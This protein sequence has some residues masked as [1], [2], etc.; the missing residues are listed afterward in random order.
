MFLSAK[1]YIPIGTKNNFLTYQLTFLSLCPACA[2]ISFEI[3]NLVASLPLIVVGNSNIKKRYGRNLK[4]SSCTFHVLKFV[5]LEAAL[6]GFVH[7]STSLALFVRLGFFLESV[8]SSVATWAQHLFSYSANIWRIIVSFFPH[9]MFTG[10]FEDSCCIAVLQCPFSLDL[11][12][13][14]TFPHRLCILDLR[15]LRC[16]CKYCL[17][18]YESR[19]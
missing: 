8:V 17:V 7:W 12:L 4:W 10:V 2:P 13:L 1:R 11:I 16:F 9:E 15:S 18:P 5:V 3:W 19:I 14:A 6:P